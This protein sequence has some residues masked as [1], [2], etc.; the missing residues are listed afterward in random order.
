[1]L[2]RLYPT[3]YH[4]ALKLLGSKNWLNVKMTEEGAFSSVE[5]EYEITESERRVLTVETELTQTG[6]RLRRF[7]G[8]FWIKESADRTGIEVRNINGI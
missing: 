1:M 7:L 3:E 6:D 2:E 8:D 5:R 4:L